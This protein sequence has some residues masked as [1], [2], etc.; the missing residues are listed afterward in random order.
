MYRSTFFKDFIDHNVG[1]WTTNNA[2]TPDPDK[3]PDQLV[4]TPIQWPLLEVGLRM[5]GWGDSEIKFYLLGTP[6]IWW[7]GAGAI[8]L[9]VVVT[10][11]YAVFWQ[12]GAASWS[13]GMVNGS[14]LDLH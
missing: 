11:L 3:E 2:L 7:G 6:L 12:R 14:M 8:V 4:S 9:F 1:M 13:D 5:C 10:L